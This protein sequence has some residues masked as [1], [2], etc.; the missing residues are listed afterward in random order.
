MTDKSVFTPEEWSALR[1]TPHL[2]ALA[3]ATAGASGVIG[4][5]QEAFSSSAGLVQ[6]MKSEH[7]L[8]GA[9]CT[10]EEISAAQ[11]SLRETLAALRG[12]GAQAAREKIETLALEK[13]RTGM[14]AL[15]RKGAPG[16]AQ[17]YADFVKGFS[18]RVAEAAKEGGFLGFGGERVSAGER[19]VLASLDAALRPTTT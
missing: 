11:Q 2:A 16:D 13:V 17:A 1:D 8:I 4:S 3:V 19:Q 7:P 14:E 10:R 6:A 18:R 15:S 9:L 12:S 5:L